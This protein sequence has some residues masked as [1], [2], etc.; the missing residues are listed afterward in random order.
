M[1]LL[2]YPILKVSLTAIR[3]LL[4]LLSLSAASAMGCHSYNIFHALYSNLHK[5]ILQTIKTPEASKVTKKSKAKHSDDDEEEDDADDNMDTNV[6]NAD[7][8]E[9]NLDIEFSLSQG[10]SHRTTRQQQITKAT[11]QL[12]RALFKDFT[13]T[14]ANKVEV[15]GYVKDEEL[16]FSMA[17]VLLN[18]LYLSTIRSELQSKFSP[19]LSLLHLFIANHYHLYIII[20]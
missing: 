10:R 9:G 20:R 13:Q 17:E 5:I 16:L 2:I 7:E 1:Q 18:C 12:T 8:E 19:P 11:G 6:D 14:L 15:L 4:H 3:A